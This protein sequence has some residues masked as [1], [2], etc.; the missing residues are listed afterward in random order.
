MSVI[1]VH[2]EPFKNLT[3][4]A[5]YLKLP[6]GRDAPGDGEKLVEHSEGADPLYCCQTASLNSS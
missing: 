2:I 1:Q 5:F 4:V 6:G 3:Q